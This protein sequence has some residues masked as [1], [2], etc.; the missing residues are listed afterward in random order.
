M[1]F[2]VV[3]DVIQVVFVVMDVGQVYN[4][5]VVCEVIGYQDV[6][7]GFKGG[8]DVVGLMLG[9]K[10]G[11]YWFNNVICNLINYQFM[12]FLFDVDIGCVVVV[13]GGNLLMVLC[14]VVVLVVLIKYLVLKGVKVLGMIGVGY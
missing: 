13:V 12:V 8:F 9:L 6:F 3:F 11:G 10:V 5:F 1:I 14:M 2:D 4:F 7:Y